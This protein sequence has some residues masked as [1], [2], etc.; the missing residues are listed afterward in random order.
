[1]LLL[2]RITAEPDVTPDLPSCPR[3]SL[4]LIHSVK[5]SSHI[6]SNTYNSQ[7]TQVSQTHIVLC[8]TASAVLTYL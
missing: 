4:Q 2:P 6:A 8:S 3:L 1:M 7:I 5:S